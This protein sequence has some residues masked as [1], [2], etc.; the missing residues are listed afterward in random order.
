M[1]GWA[2]IITGITII[3]ASTAITETDPRARFASYCP[4][5]PRGDQVRSARHCFPSGGRAGTFSKPCA[6]RCEFHLAQGGSR[7][8]PVRVLGND[9]LHLGVSARRAAI[10]L[11]PV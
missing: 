9:G 1:P 6:P 11:L 5:A 7:T 2:A 8:A 3:I 4:A 10:L